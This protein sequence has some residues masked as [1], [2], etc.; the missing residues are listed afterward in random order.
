MS[1]APCCPSADPGNV[2]AVLAYAAATV[3]GLWGVAHAGPTRQVLAGYA[4]ITPDN[5]RVLLQEWLAEAIT[6][7]GIAALVI[8]VTAIGSGTSTT[9]WVYRMAAALLVA[10]ALL[11]GLTGARTPVIWFK[12]CPALL[13]VSAAL[14]LIAS[15]G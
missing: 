4:P 1:L 5:R 10:L 12:I 7:W 9:A 13:S 8:V 2:S 6:M 3:T 15:F 14:L 11:T